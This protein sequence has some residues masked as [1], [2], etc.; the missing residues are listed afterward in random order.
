MCTKS[1]R[2]ERAYRDRER[3]RDS[4]SRHGAPPRE[5][6]APPGGAAAV[7]RRRSPAGP[8][9][10]GG[11]GRPRLRADALVRPASSALGRPRQAGR[12]AGRRTCSA[13]RACDGCRAT[14]GGSFAPAMAAAAT[15]EGGEGRRLGGAEHRTW[16]GEGG[17]LVTG[18]RESV[19]RERERERVGRAA[20]GDD[21]WPHGG[22]GPRGNPNSC[23]RGGITTPGPARREPARH[24][25][26]RHHQ[27]PPP[28]PSPPSHTDRC[29]ARHRERQWV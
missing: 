26:C 15:G 18:S 14:G 13:R 4:Q 27:R 8:A 20:A 28:P 10:E 5:P 1:E 3:E 9:G 22:R 17:R 21:L 25:C 2:G 19:E 23:G 11:G 16:R 24:H 6:H 12:Q 29:G 7:A